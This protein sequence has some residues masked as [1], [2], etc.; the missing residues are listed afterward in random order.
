MKT[1]EKSL[2]RFTVCLEK[3]LLSRLDEI[4]SERGYP[5]RSQA[6]ADFIRRA[7][8]KREWKGGRECAGT[9]SLVYDPA[10]SRPGRGIEALLF[11]NAKSVLSS[12][13]HLLRGGKLLCTI[14]VT[15]RPSALQSLAD[16]LRALKGV[17]HGSFSIIAPL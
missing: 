4:A 14:A 16:T 9:I 13:A 5:S 3:G 12:Q 11:A 10:D 17:T 6:M 15:G 8:V 1:T 7:I 2:D